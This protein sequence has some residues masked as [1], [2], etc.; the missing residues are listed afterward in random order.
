[1]TIATP[2]MYLMLDVIDGLYAIARL[3]AQDADMFVSSPSASV[4]PRL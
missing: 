2:S 4:T 3:V 1:M